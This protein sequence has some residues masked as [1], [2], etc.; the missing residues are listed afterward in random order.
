MAAGITSRTS[1][2]RFGPVS[3]FNWEAPVRLPPG[4][5]KLATRLSSTGLAAV[6]KTVGTVVVTALAASAAGVLVA[7]STAT[8]R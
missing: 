7:A 2:S 6:V 3:T 8:G 1:S 5:L 4:R